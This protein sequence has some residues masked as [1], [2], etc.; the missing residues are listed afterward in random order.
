[1]RFVRAQGLAEVWGSSTWDWQICGLL[2][3][4][5]ALVSH[6]P[7][8]AVMLVTTRTWCWCSLLRCLPA[9][10]H[11]AS[12][13]PTSAVPMTRSARLAILPF[14]VSSVREQAS[15]ARPGASGRKHVPE[16]AA[17]VRYR[18]TFPSPAGG[19]GN[20]QTRWRRRLGNAE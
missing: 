2:A 5:L 17:Q 9:G 18:S 11:A 12:A 14:V 19:L 16:P 7:G 20:P 15:K 8:S 1:V 10:Q 4:N 13:Q 6:L 3:L